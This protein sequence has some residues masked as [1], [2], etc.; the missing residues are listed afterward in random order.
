MRNLIQN[1]ETMIFSLIGALMGGISILTYD[2][3]LFHSQIFASARDRIIDPIFLYSPIPDRIFELVFD[4]GKYD[5]SPFF[6]GFGIIAFTLGFYY[7]TKRKLFD[8]TLLN[9]LVMISVFTLCGLAFSFWLHLSAAAIEFTST[10]PFYSLIVSF[11]VGLFVFIF[12]ATFLGL[13]DNLNAVS[14]SP[15]LAL[16]IPV[17][18]VMSPPFNFSTNVTLGLVCCLLILTVVYITIEYH[19]KEYFNNIVFNKSVMGR[20]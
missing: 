1:R 15:L 17:L 14:R 10:V 3:G 4:T 6:N 16:L 5:P 8:N 13:P 11:A 19:Y 7:S 20:V 12:C 18:L 9:K 2:L